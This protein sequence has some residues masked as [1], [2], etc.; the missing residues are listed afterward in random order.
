MAAGSNFTDEQRAGYRRHF[1]NFEMSLLASN[2]GLSIQTMHNWDLVNPNAQ[3]A[4]GF[5]LTFL[6]PNA[7]VIQSWSY[8]GD[9]SPWMNP[10]VSGSLG[11]T[12]FNGQTYH[13]HTITWTAAKS[14]TGGSPG[15]VPGGGR[16]HI[17]ATF[18]GVDFNQPDPIIITRSEL[19]D[20]SG[21]ALTLS[22]RLPGYDAGTLDSADGTF[23][24]AFTNFAAQ[25]LLI[26]DVLVRQFP[27]I[28]SI[29]SLL[30]GAGL[31]DPLG[32]PLRPWPKTTTTLL[33]KPVSLKRRGERT[34]T[35][36]RLAQKRHIL[37]RVTTGCKRGDST[38]E[39]DVRFCRAG[40]SLDLFPATTF[41]VRVTVIEPHV[42]HWD[43]KA[44]RYVVGD[45]TETVF[46]QV[47]GR[48]PDLNRNRRDDAIDIA[49]GR[50]KDSN[51]D[52]V[53]DEAQRKRRG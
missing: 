49:S 38:V 34:V 33:Q 2:V 43:R 45:L 5:R 11:T 10:S 37:K 48:H 21:N 42:K 4:N 46:L 50:S 35:I 31:V 47:G 29:N 25:P 24:L 22:P 41:L 1:S 16:F 12:T 44:R 27:T 18:S 15:I 28:V 9:R 23:K 3:S 20:S 40:W 6:S 30:S 7:S 39:P 14:W 19:L 13:R 26:R 36:A 17:G 52:G 8:T 32:V 51:R 53:P